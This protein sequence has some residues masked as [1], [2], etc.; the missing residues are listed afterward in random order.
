MAIKKIKISVV[1]ED[2]DKGITT[3]SKYREIETEKDMGKINVAISH[4]VEEI[5]GQKPML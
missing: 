2:E 1:S 5:T 3:T 4:L